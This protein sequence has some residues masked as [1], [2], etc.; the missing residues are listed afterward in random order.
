MSQKSSLVK[1][2][3]CVPRVLTSDNVDLAQVARDTVSMLVAEARGK[4]ID[5]GYEGAESMP[6][7]GDPTLL[8]E[9]A[10]NLADNALRYSPA[11]TMVTL[12]VARID[13]AVSLTV[14]DQGPGIPEDMRDEV[15]ERFVRLP[16]TTV[17]GCGLGLAI[18]RE[19]ADRHGGQAGLE[20][21]PGGGL[22]VRVDFPVSRD[23]GP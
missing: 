12:S 18:V 5:L 7:T 17:E 1:T 22:R 2:P 19:I 3:Q 15:F 8:G 6:I 14:D 20:R 13:G 11:G 23:G 10:I 9:M 4:D 16:G 21:S